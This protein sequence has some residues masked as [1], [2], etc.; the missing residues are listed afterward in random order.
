MDELASF[1]GYAYDLLNT[2]VFEK[3]ASHIHNFLKA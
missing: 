2:D 3:H 1:L